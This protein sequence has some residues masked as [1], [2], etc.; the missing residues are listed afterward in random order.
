MPNDTLCCCCQSYIY[1]K[2]LSFYTVRYDKC[3]LVV[4]KEALDGV[5]VEGFVSEAVGDELE[6]DEAVYVEFVHA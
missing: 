6:Q 3:S 4:L 2:C 5:R 1:A